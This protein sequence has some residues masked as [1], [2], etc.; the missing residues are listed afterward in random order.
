MAEPAYTVTIARDLQDLV[1]QF[2]ANRRTELEALR[3]AL[4][5]GRYRQLG[6]LGHRMRGVG[7]S[8]GFDRVSV[9]GG[10]IEAG[11]ARTN[12]DELAARIAE[13]ADY[14]ARVTVVYE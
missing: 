1:P 8:Y 7:T 12:Y 10:Q 13:Y 5:A 3:S 4:A 2:I 9:L 14:L 11:A 6:E